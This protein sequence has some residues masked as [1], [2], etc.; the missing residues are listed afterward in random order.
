[1]RE[2]AYGMPVVM[3]SFVFLSPAMDWLV[4]HNRNTDSFVAYI[5]DQNGAIV[6]APIETVDSCK[7]IVHFSCEMCG[8][9][10]VLFGIN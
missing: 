1:M 3:Q 7:F 6:L 5:K 10:D 9:V 4:Q 2:A 8:R